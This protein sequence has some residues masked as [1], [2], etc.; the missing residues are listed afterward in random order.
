MAALRGNLMMSDKEQEL[1]DAVK[2]IDYS[3]RYLMQ[4]VMV[5]ANQKWQ[6]P[7]IAFPEKPK[8]QR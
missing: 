8:S 6:I 7:P 2:S 1:L 3:L 4:Y 5:I